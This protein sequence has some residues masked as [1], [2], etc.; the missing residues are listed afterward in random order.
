MGVQP[1]PKPGTF[2]AKFYS[3]TVRSACCPVFSVRYSTTLGVDTV[4][5]D[6]A[7][8]GRCLKTVRPYMQ[9]CRRLLLC[10]RF[11]DKRQCVIVGR[12]YFKEERHFNILNNQ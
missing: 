11:G 4:M 6:G 10:Q 8:D 3:V 7:L 2:Q 12:R 9:E 5:Q 1:I